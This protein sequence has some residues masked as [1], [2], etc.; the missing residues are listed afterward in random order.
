MVDFLIKPKINRDA[1]EMRIGKA[2][3]IGFK[4]NMLF[5]WFYNAPNDTDAGPN[6]A[7]L[8]QKFKLKNLNI[9]FSPGELS[10]ICSLTGC[11]KTLLI[12]S[13]MGEMNCLSGYTI[14]PRR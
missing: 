5:Q 10:I 3:F 2:K 7:N 12:S 1:H 11:G 9:S 14:L 6:P 4:N 13:L 8:G